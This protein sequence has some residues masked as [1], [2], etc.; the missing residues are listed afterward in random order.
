MVLRKI[1]WK[2]RASKT[3][4][5]TPETTGGHQWSKNPRIEQGIL[6]DKA[7]CRTEPVQLAHVAVVP[8]MDA[9]GSR[10][11]GGR[12]GWKIATEPPGPPTRY[13]HIV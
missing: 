4:G 11:T 5:Q 9:V 7:K 3:E 13:Y 12:I 10:T 1:S 6:N 2:K 8:E